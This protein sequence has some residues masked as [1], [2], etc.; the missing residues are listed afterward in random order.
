MNLRRASFAWLFTILLLTVLAG[1]SWVDLVLTP[2]SGGQQIQVTG[3][4]VFPIISALLL[5]QA[6]AL[7]AAFFT[8]S[9][10]GRIITAIQLPI[11]LWHATVVLTTTQLALQDAV[12]AEITKATGVVGVSSQ[13]QLVELALDNN[14]WYVY[15]A[16]LALN[17][18]ALLARALV[19]ESRPK[20]T[21]GSEEPNDSDDLWES[22][23]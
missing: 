2:A 14:L 11:V 15:L 10:V 12:A 20:S 18:F 23:R 6:A 5:F 8:P 7:L 4:L 19:S 16:V 1:F 13:A 22:Q 9:L 17:T 21:A 3:F